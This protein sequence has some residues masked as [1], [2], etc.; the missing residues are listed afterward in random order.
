MSTTPFFTIIALPLTLV[1]IA[2]EMDLSFPSI[3]SWEWSVS[4]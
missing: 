3:M 2:A 1:I 4:H